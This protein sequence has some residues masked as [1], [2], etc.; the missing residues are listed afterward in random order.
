[1]GGLV[2]GEDRKLHA[3]DDPLQQGE[4]FE[5]AMTPHTQIACKLV[6]LRSQVAERIALTNFASA[7]RIFIFAQRGDNVGK[8]LQGS[9]DVLEDCRTQTGKRKN[10]NYKDADPHQHRYVP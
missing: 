3:F 4:C 2:K 7:K 6:D 8:S 9:N 10:K 5:L 1:F